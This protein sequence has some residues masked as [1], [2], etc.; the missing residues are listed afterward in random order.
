MEVQQVEARLP[1]SLFR[2]ALGR[3]GGVAWTD[4]RRVPSCRSRSSLARAQTGMRRLCTGR[5]RSPGRQE[6][7]SRPARDRTCSG[8][9][10][11]GQ[12]EQGAGSRPARVVVWAV[13][14]RVRPGRGRGLDQRKVESETA[15]AGS[16]GADSGKLEA[17]SAVAGLRVTMAAG[18]LRRRCSRRSSCSAGQGTKML[19]QTDR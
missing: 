18:T 17:G 13:R 6:A 14:R 2:P 7:G 8:Q 16:S 12:D 10:R 15:G 5:G 3:R 19:N 9:Q 4:Q 11:E 1:A